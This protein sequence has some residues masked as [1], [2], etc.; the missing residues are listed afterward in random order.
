MIWAADQTVNSG[1]LST[2]ST[3]PSYRSVL[4]GNMLSYDTQLIDEPREVFF[5]RPNTGGSLEIMHHSVAGSQIA[6]RGN[7]KPLVI[8]ICLIKELTLTMVELD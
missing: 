2:T 7:M 4:L 3:A 5:V 6:L 1:L 8:H